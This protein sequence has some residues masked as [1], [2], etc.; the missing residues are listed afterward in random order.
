MDQ[1]K[2]HAMKARVTQL[3]GPDCPRPYARSSQRPRQGISLRR[4]TLLFS[5]NL[6][7]GACG[8]LGTRALGCG[9]GAGGSG[10]AARDLARRLMRG[11]IDWSRRLIDNEGPAGKIRDLLSDLTAR[12]SSGQFL[13][14]A[15]FH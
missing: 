5:G 3:T 2:Q 14:S 1:M 12:G 6:S 9:S 13:T 11:T 4:R 15:L 8:N 10:R 7:R